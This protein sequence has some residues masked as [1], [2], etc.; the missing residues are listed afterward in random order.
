MPR[1]PES[2][3]HRSN[4]DRD[5]SPNRSRRNGKPAIEKSP[6]RINPDA[7]CKDEDKKQRR[8]HADALPLESQPEPNSKVVERGMGDESQRNNH[9]QGER[10]RNSDATVP[11]SRSY[12]QHDERD[13][14]RQ[15]GRSSRHRTSDRGWWRDF[16]DENR[17]SKDEHGAPHKSAVS[18]V[19]G[20]H[21]KSAAQGDDSQVWRH[22]KF[23]EAQADLPP[24][25]KKRRPFR[26]EKLLTDSELTEKVVGQPTTKASQTD[27]PAGENTRRGEKRGHNPQYADRNERDHA[28]R[29]DR[30]LPNRGRVEK[31]GSPYKDRYTGGGGRYRGQDSYGG[32]QGYYPGAGNDKKWEHDL[33]HAANRS[34]TPKNEE[35]PVA[36]VEALLAS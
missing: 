4:S 32:R 29:T 30:S 14:A 35:D 16:K 31:S 12:F 36:K 15:D 24:P 6:S 10:A 18:D 7:G 2:R 9:G 5:P 28:Y 34:P 1:E 33:F 22:D 17:N 13:H 27:H 26:E 3:R 11:R 20:R 25:A 19:Q 23:F 21:D 8:R